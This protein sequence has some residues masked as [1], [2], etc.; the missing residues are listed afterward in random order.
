MRIESVDVRACRIDA[1][2]IG[3]SQLRGTQY[4]FEF[5]VT[6][7]TTEDGLSASSFGFAGRSARGA[8]ELAAASLRPFFVGRDALSRERLWQEFRTADRWWNHLPIYSYGPFDVCLWLLGALDAG[9]SLSQYL[10]GYR[11]SLPTYMSSLVHDT[12]A[13]YAEEALAVRA[14]G[15]HGYKLHTPGRTFDEDLEAHRLVREAVGPDFRLMSDPV[16]AHN[17]HDAIR[18]GKELEKLDYYWYEEPLFDEDFEGLR[19]LK[20]ALDI[21]IVGTEVVAK[22]PYSV[23]P[24]ITEGLVDRVRADV[25]WSG[26]VTSVMKTAHLAEAFGMNIEVHTA[27]FHPLELVNLHVAAAISNTEFFEILS[28][29]AAFDWGLASPINIEDGMAHVPKGPG[30][31]IDFDW[32]FI[33]DCTYAVL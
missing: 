3:A 6:S 7:L 13:G 19:R 10:G 29:R 17:L 8:G 24:Y 1:P 30:L 16:A 21:P 20:A 5:L 18:F 4:S 11:D 14:E 23:T 12:P 25:S 32:D 31:G 28:P 9:Q 22:H 33:D 15:F 27:L 26:G 2:D